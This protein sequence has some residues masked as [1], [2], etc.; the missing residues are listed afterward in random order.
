MDMN[1]PDLTSLFDQ[2]GLPSSQQDIETFISQHRIKA[3]IHL[4]EADFWNDAQKNF[5]K[6]ALSDDASWA[7]IVDQLDAQLRD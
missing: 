1:Q 7:E 4:I 3:S 2:L 5:L 6:E